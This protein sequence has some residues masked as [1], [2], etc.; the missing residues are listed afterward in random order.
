MASLS[1]VALHQRRTRFVKEFLI[2]QNATRAAIAAGYAAKSATVTASRLLSDVKV[3]AAIERENEKA[4]AKVDITVERVKLE[5]ARLAFYD[6]G[7]YWNPDGSAK[8]FTDLDEDARRAIAGFEMAELFTGTG[9]DRGLAGYIKKFKLADKGA[10]LERLG[11][12]L[13]MFPTKVEI[14]GEVIHKI[15]DGDLNKR[16]AELERDLGL[17][18][19]IDDAGRIGLAQAGAEA[20]NGKTQ[21]ADILPGN[22]AVKA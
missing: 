2:D 12:H 15:D 6:P 21:T 18:A 17:A 19:A 8:A 16:I 13:Q 5:L 11:R 10:N 1:K 20:T 4:N 9:E 22:G 3:R 14:T 7:A